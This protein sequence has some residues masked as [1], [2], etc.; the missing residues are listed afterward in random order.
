MILYDKADQ[1]FATS[2]CMLSWL[3]FVGL[4]WHRDRKEQKLA[5]H[6]IIGVPPRTFLRLIVRH[7]GMWAVWTGIDDM[8]VPY[9]RWRGTYIA[10]Y[11]NGT[12]Y[13]C[14]VQPDG[15]EDIMQVK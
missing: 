5:K 7:R 1:I 9:E 15:T 3:I 14:I 8:Q 2:L 4:C 11:D 13:R 12:A 6:D 10:L